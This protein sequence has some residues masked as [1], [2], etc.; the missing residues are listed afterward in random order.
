MTDIQTLLNEEA[1]SSDAGD[2]DE[3]RKVHI[4]LKLKRGSTP[5]A[6]WGFDDCST[7]VLASCPWRID[8]DS[9][10]ANE[11]QDNRSSDDMDKGQ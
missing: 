4:M 9:H 10:A 6:C 3:V 5:P 8:C 1:A 2:Y 7:R 11:W